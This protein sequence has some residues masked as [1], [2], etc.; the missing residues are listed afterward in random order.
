VDPSDSER[1]QNFPSIFEANYGRVHAYAARRVGADAADDVAAET[2]MIAW[3]RRDALPAE[4]LPW[5]YGIARNLV[6]RQHHS[7]ARR[8]AL[9]RSLELERAGPGEEPAGDPALATAWAALRRGD[10]EV[11]ALIAWEELSV[12]EAATAMGV[13]APV[14]S[15][16]LHRARRRFEAL[17]GHDAP[18][19][20]PVPEP[21][22]AS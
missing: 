5:L 16:R 8:R 22:E 10:R 9:H 6:A 2:M 19:A 12:H 13:S 3:R 21:T 18:A 11:L 20:D 14:F 15:V 17:L 4:P 1:A 7:A